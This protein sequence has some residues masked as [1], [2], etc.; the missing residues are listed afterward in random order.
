MDASQILG[1]WSNFMVMIGS[2][3]AALTG[4]TFVV[5][6]LIRGENATA[7]GVGT[8]TTPTVM[9]FASVLLIAATLL[10]PWH[11][12]T[13]VAIPT[14]LIGFCGIAYVGQVAQRVR[15]LSSYTP[16]TEDWIWFTIAP[17][18]AY[19]AVFAGGIALALIP[20]TA[21]FVVAAGA[22]LL[23]FVGIRNAWDVTTY[24]AISRG[25]P[26]GTP[27]G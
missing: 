8:F 20:F 13:H 10:A 7:E 27:N 1:G 11:V 2:S 26:D 19:V 15:R 22:V 21:L 17:V 24:I 23:L 25:R 9:H 12:L 4:L 5:T 16:D 14:A 3:S 6:T 18:V